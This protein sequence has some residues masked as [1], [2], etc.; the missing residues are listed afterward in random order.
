MYWVYVLNLYELRC[1]Q[2]QNL[3]CDDSVEKDRS[4]ILH[5]SEL[6]ELVYTDR[7][8]KV[9]QGLIVKKCSL[10]TL[11]VKIFIFRIKKLITHLIKIAL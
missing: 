11:I 10:S 5:D 7:R 6:L 8:V 1:L 3:S 4:K 9:K 2:G